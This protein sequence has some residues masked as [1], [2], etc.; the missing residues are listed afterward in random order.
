M[1]LN[2]LSSIKI[3]AFSWI[4]LLRKDMYFAFKN[5]NSLYIAKVVLLKAENFKIASK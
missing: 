4:L 3:M 5:L 1:F 2:V